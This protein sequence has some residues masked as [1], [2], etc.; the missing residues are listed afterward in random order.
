MNEE[1]S[2]LYTIKLETRLGE[3]SLENLIEYVF[4]KQYMYYSTNE[5]KIGRIPRDTINKAFRLISDSRWIEI[6]M[7]KFNK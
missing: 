2:K 3:I 1:S 4:A 5:D 6:K 7:K